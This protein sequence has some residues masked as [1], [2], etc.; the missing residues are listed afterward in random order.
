MEK[1]KL[2]LKKGGIQ[3]VKQVLT[4]INRQVSKTV[5]L[6]FKNSRIAKGKVIRP[7]RLILRICVLAFRKN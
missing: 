5:P 4:A 3:A 7:L 6:D 1:G 2:P